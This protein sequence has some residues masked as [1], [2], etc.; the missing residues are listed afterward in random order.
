MIKSMTGYGQFNS[1]DAQCRQIW[2]IKSVNSKQLNLRWKLP[3]ELGSM[4]YFWD[5]E[6]HSLAL[7]GKIDITL[8]LQFLQSNLLPLSFNRLSAEAMI[9]Q[10]TSFASNRGEAFQADYNHF[11]T[12]PGLWQESCESLEEGLMQ[13]LK[14]GL[15]TAL[16]DWDQSRVREGQAL[17]EDL[18]KRLVVIQNSIIDLK[19][20]SHSLAEEKFQNLQGRLSNL[21]ESQ[22]VEVEQDRMWQE[23][24]LLS[25][26]VDI[27]EE[28]I[29]L[30]THVGNLSSLL[31]TEQVGGRKLDFYLQESFREIN[32]CGN[33]AQDAKA[34]Q[35]V[36]EC[37]T[38]LEKCRE[39]VQNLE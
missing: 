8:K 29:R 36:V 17:K 39:Q 33:K 27:S 1:Q 32:T 35:F 12:M 22:G 5:N 15:R 10:L 21:L 2:E 4:D 11:L 24:A 19:N 37:K 13:S 26:K 28:L 6:V 9:D 18:L 14:S 7:R 25:D 31:Q 30:E 34:S 3:S 23:L 38:E 20:R 16:E